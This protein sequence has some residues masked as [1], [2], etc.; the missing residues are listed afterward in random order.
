METEDRKK[1]SKSCEIQEAGFCDN[2][3]ADSTQELKAMLPTLPVILIDDI[4]MARKVTVPAQP[5]EYKR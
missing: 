4:C 1:G 5:A 2:E 3:L